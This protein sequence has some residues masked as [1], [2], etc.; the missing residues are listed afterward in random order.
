MRRNV[1]RRVVRILSD[2]SEWVYTPI[3]P[4]H[5]RC[6]WVDFAGVNTLATHRR[7]GGMK[8]TDPSEKVNEAKC[9]DMKT[10]SGVFRSSFTRVEPVLQVAGGL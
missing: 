6:K 4:I 10:T 3:P 2:V 9:H 8:T 1:H 7:E 5:R